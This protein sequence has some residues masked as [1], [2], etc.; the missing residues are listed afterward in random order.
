MWHLTAHKISVS[1]SFLNWVKNEMIF[2]SISESVLATLIQ[3]Y[4]NK[5]FHSRTR[6]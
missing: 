3:R 1:L 4:N 2:Y 5:A 6:D